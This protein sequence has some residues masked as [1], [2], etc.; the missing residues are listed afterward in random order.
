ML[1]SRALAAPRGD[2]RKLHDSDSVM[3]V[4]VREEAHLVVLIG[5]ICIQHMQIPI[6]QPRHVSRAKH[7]VTEFH[8]RDG[9]LVRQCLQTAKRRHGCGTTRFSMC[10]MPSISTRTTSPLCK[11]TGGCLAPPTP[12]GEP[13]AR[14]SPGSSVNTV[15]SSSI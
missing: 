8:R 14:M 2:S 4:I 7:D 3:L 10:P 13:V 15:V 9:C 5:H 6:T 11:Y 1:E 12:A